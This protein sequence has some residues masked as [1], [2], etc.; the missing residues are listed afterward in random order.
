MRTFK[1]RFWDPVLK[2]MIYDLESLDSNSKYTLGISD[3]ELFIG[4]EDVYGDWYELVKMQSTGV[5]DMNNKEIYEG[6]LLN[7]GLAVGYVSYET[8]E[9]VLF[10][11][12]ESYIA[13]KSC[14]CCSYKIVGNIYE[15]ATIAESFNGL[16][17]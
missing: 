14:R 17:Y 7:I 16:R 13:I 4:R 3:G 1:F 2:K 11:P 8:N 5:T 9:L 12:D 6:D 10:E 15:N